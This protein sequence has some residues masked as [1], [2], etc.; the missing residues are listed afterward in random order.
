MHQFRADRA[1]AGDPAERFPRG[2][3][4]FAREH[5]VAT[6]RVFTVVLAALSLAGMWLVSW[7][8]TAHYRSPDAFGVLLTLAVVVPLAWR[9]QR[10][11][12]VL[13]IS[14]AA[15]FAY[16]AIGY[17]SGLAWLATFWAVY[18][19]AV[20]RRRR[21]AYWPLAVWLAVIL[22][23]PVLA[24]RG[25]TVPSAL[26]FLAITA[27]VWI[28]G[29]TVRS[30]LLQA[31][32]EREARARQAVA[33]ERARIARELHDVVSQALG[34]IV[35]Q[36]GGAGSVPRLAEADAKAALG[37]IERTGRQA[38]AE[39]RR[40]VGVLRDDNEAPAIAPQPTL[41][42]IP[43]LLAR[44]ADGGL[45]VDLQAEGE[46]RP[47]PAGVGLSAY[48]IVQ[49]ALTNTLKHAGAARA[50]VRLVWSA[51]RLDIEVTD[52]GPAAGVTAPARVRPDSGGNGLV[53]MRERVMLYGGELE[54][55]P[56]AGGAG[57]RVVA[58]LPLGGPV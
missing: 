52:D 42:E 58:R 56:A 11:D 27:F 17:R 10:P 44:L 48:R 16:D 33:D 9:R 32:R 57:Y 8:S 15:L 13:V 41:D 34:V 19:Y 3:A 54:A 51:D 25:Y 18:S 14:A 24:G 21:D 12:L 23:L 31:E 45:D 1:D 46:P 35:M 7:S 55:G 6:D 39:M 20:Y 37:T 2:V 49:E 29:D 50:R 28:R 4:A 40:L 5:P 30:G 43:A 26:I 53:G 36:A 38:F 47:V 22:A